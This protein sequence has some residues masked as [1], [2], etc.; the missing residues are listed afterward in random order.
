MYIIFVSYYA[1]TAM[2]TEKR[3]VLCTTTCALNSGLVFTGSPTFR[4]FLC[5]LLL[6]ELW[7]A[8][9]VGAAAAAA[10]LS[11]CTKNCV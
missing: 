11:F 9:F 2:A 5:R 4:A 3:R 7:R 6:C 1:T 10:S 8:G